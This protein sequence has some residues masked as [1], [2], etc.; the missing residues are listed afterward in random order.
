MYIA[1]VLLVHFERVIIIAPKI[2]AKYVCYPGV[3]ENEN[4]NEKN[5][6]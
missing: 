1:T 3:N 6:G 5:H 4:E 2:H